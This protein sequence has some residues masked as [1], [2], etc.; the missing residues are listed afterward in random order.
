MDKNSQETSVILTDR[1][2]TVELEAICEF[3]Q[4]LTNAYIFKTHF[5]ENWD[6]TFLFLKIF[7][8]TQ[9]HFQKYIYP[10]AIAKNT[11]KSMPRPPGLVQN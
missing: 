8:F 2:D 10:Q 6:F 11:V 1:V 7:L 5:S 3:I 4:W 9:A